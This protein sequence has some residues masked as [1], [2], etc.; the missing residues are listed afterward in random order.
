MSTVPAPLLTG[1]L[2]IITG[3]QLIW[4]FE[5]LR[6]TF[7]YPDILRQP[8]ADILRKYH[9]A[10]R[11]LPLLWLAFALSAL[12]AL[13]AVVLLHQA[14]ASQGGVFYLGLTTAVGVVAAIFNLLGLSRWIFMVPLLASRYLAPTSSPA[15]REAIEVVF[16][17]LHTYLGLTI[18]EFWG[19]T[20][21]AVWG[22]LIALALMAT[23][24]IAPWLGILGI[25]FSVGVFMGVFEFAGWKPAG[26]IVAI[27]SALWALWLVAVGITFLI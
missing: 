24:L 9:A 14:V 17:T 10:G 15:T 27:S 1:V 12:L 22:I 13:A 25:L 23:G 6:R 20:L 4:P 11:R 26:I 8:T 16:E 2:L 21:L 19:F 7:E 18:G 5:M 3:L